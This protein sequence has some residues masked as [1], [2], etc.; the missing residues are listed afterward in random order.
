MKFLNFTSILC[1][2]LFFLLP[3]NNITGQ[4][5]EEFSIP[6]RGVTGCQGSSGGCHVSDY[7]GVDWVINGN[8]AGFDA[9]DFVETNASGVLFFSGDIDEELCFESPILDISA[10][11]GSFSISVDIVWNHHDNAEYVDVEYD[12]DNAGWVTVPIQFGDNSGTGHTVDFSGSGNTGSGTVSVS[13]LTGSNTLK[14]RVCAD[15]NTASSGESHSIDNI[16]VPEANVLVLPIELMSFTANKREDEVQLNWTTATE[17]NNE[18]FQI[19]HS[20]DGKSFDKIGEIKGSINTISPTDYSFSHGQP[21]NGY[22]YYRLKQVDVNGQYEY[23]GIVSANIETTY[24]DIGSF[25]PNPSSNGLV[26]LEYNSRSNSE[27]VL[28]IYSV[29]GNFITTKSIP[30]IKGINDL[31]INLTDLTN[32]LYLIKV[33]S[34]AMSKWRKVIIK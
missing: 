9:D 33:D 28:S 25:Y 15:S 1:S 27:L 11:P 6:N 23:S 22:N 17:L 13:G 14:V 31:N 18:K 7:T 12:I 4:Y 24:K 5:L 10:V 32:G 20:T 30:V 2:I 8:F 16:D 34:G 29:S 19:E 3:I 21:T 26:N